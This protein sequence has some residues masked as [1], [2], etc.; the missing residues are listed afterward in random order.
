MPV[1]VSKATISLLIVFVPVRIAV[2]QVQPPGPYIFD[3]TYR[4]TVLLGD[5]NSTQIIT[6]SA[7]NVSGQETFT[8][9]G[10]VY[11]PQSW[12][13]IITSTS[14][15]SATLIGSGTAEGGTKPLTVSGGGIFLSSSGPVTDT[16]TLYW[17]GTFPGF[18]T[19]PYT[20]YIGAGGEATM[21]IAY[22]SVI[23]SA[24]KVTVDGAYIYATFTPNFGLS[25]QDAAA[26]VATMALIG[27]RP[28]RIYQAQ[29]HTWPF[30]I[31]VYL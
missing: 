23:A 16:F 13:G 25:L 27:P 9:S 29:A 19:G 28:L 5:N 7:L 18:S 26:L 6:A 21:N 15:L 11:G 12:S 3:G 8:M 30:Q 20:T 31:Q 2:A 10:P 24:V 1:R 17:G 22:E 4:S 14:G